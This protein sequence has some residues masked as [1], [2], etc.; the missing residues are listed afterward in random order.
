MELI[1]AATDRDAG[2]DGLN[3]FLLSNLKIKNP[4]THIVAAVCNKE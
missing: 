4:Q 2:G 1:L 3:H